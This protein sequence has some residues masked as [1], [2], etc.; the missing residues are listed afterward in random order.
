MNIIC[1]FV[2]TYGVCALNER[3]QQALNHIISDYKRVLKEAER[4]KNMYEAEHEIHLVRN[5]QLDRKEK[6]IIRCNELENENKE[7]KKK[8]I[9]L[10]KVN[11][12]LKEIYKSEKKMKN[13]YVKLYQNLLLK[14]EVISVQKIKDKIEEIS[15]MIDYEHNDKVIIQLAKQKRVLQKLLDGNDTNV[16]SIGNED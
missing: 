7:L 10:Q 5:E 14:E 6:A 4:Y 11:E 1:Q 3:E 15:K 8:N 12:E 2:V 16:G 13:E 9:E